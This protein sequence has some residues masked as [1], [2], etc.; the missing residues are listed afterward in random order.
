MEEQFYLVWPLVVLAV[1]HLARRVSGPEPSRFLSVCWISMD[2]P[3]CAGHVT[4]P[5][6]G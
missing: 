4:G 2:V 6:G 5:T 3:G 1:L